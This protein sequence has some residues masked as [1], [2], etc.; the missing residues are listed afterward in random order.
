MFDVV[1]S[2]VGYLVSA[3]PYVMLIVFGVL[4]TVAVLA[5][6]A[7]VRIYGAGGGRK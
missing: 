4:A 7:R 1:G 5:R 2:F 3:L 6:R